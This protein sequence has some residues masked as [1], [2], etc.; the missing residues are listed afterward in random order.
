MNKEMLQKLYG[1]INDI[2]D[3]L[4]DF[5]RSQP[6]QPIGNHCIFIEQFGEAYIQELED[7]QLIDDQEDRW[8]L[9]QVSAIQLIDFIQYNLI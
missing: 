7:G 8:S 1:D 3:K 9:D 4:S 6:N 2:H 5:I